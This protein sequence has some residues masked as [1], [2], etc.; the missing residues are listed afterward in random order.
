MNADRISILLVDDHQV[1][2]KG[3]RLMLGTAEDI[4]VVGEAATAQEA[5]RFAGEHD[6]DVVLVDINLPDQSGLDL[7][8]RL[9]TLKPDSAAVVLTAYPEE[10]TRCARSSMAR[11]DT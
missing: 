10:P 8:K 11:P 1:V 3:I 9:R 4:D 7:I 5:L 2:R 6:V